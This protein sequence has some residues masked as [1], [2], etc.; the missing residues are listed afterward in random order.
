MVLAV[1]GFGLFVVVG[2]ESFCRVVLCV[3][4]VVVCCFVRL[5]HNVLRVCFC[6]LCLV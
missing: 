1:F 3:C 4:D 2:P 6:V 5:N